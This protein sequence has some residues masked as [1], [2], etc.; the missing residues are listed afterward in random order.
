[1]EQDQ[2][3]TVAGGWFKFGS[4]SKPNVLEGECAKAHHFPVS[5]TK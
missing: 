1:M 3:N 2:E 5:S 4:S